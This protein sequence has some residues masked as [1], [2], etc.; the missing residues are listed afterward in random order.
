MQRG[1]TPVLV[2]LENTQ[3]ITAYLDPTT[4]Q[5]DELRIVDTIRT[6]L[7]A[8]PEDQGSVETAT[9]ALI[10]PKEFLER[11]G[12]PYPELSQELQDLGSEMPGIVPRYVSVSGLLP[13]V[14]LDQFKIIPGVESVESSKDRNHSILAAFQ[15]LRSVSRLLMAGLC[16]AVLTG[17]VHLARMNAS[18]HHDVLSF[19]KLWGASELS[20]RVPGILSGLLVG[21]IGGVLAACAWVFFGAP[22][23]EHVRTLSPVLTSMPVAGLAYGAWLWLAGAC[24][25]VSSGLFSGAGAIAEHRR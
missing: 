2:R 14:T 3:V 24:L 17:L 25:G 12:K 9:V 20:V 11:L 15:A 10:G 6:S 23:A 1:L 18:L 16:L 7:G 13:G 21:L 4:S 22:L 5:K 8:A 19:L